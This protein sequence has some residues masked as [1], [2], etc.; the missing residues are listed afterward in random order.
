[1]VCP[2][3]ISKCIYPRIANWHKTQTKDFQENCYYL[4][5][6]LTFPRP[7][8]SGSMQVK[9]YI[10]KNNYGIAQKADLLKEREE[11]KED[12][13]KEARRLSHSMDQKRI[14]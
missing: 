13:E 2:F 3:T 4:Y 6:D 8:L 14:Q 10:K 12:K 1:M 5:L 11:E 7:E 9:C